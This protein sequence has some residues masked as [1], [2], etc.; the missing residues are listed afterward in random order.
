MI[1]ITVI[2]DDYKGYINLCNKFVKPTLGSS[3]FMFPRSLDIII[4]YVTM[5]LIDHL[6]CGRFLPIPTKVVNPL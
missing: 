5:Y 1:P 6:P 2:Q 3:F 4:V